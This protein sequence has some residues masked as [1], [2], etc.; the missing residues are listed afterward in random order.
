M[1]D[2]HKRIRLHPGTVNTD[3]PAESWQKVGSAFFVH[4]AVNVAPLLGARI[5]AGQGSTAEPLY[6]IIPCSSE[7]GYASHSLFICS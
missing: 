1:A 3:D 4:P 5:I 7:P 6:G 2:L